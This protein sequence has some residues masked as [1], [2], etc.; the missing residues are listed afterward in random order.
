MATM[1]TILIVSGSPSF[2][3]RNNH[4]LARSEFS[5]LTAQA[6]DEALRLLEERDPALVIADYQ[7]AD[8]SGEE[9][10]ARVRADGEDSRPAIILVCR[11]LPEDLEAL[12]ACGANA[13]IT[14]PVRPLQLIKTVGQF[15]TVQLVR[16]RRISLRVKVISRTDDLEFFCISHNISVTGMLIETEHHL[17]EGRRIVCTF[18]LPD[19]LAVETEGEIVRSARTLD[20]AHQYG[21]QFLGMSRHFRRAIDD[22]IATVARTT[23]SA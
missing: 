11:E 7:L 22:Y 21:I 12:A 4:L 17:D 2:L 15:L 10:C 16:S 13:V 18:S 6:S 20:G 1:K 5:I 23:P 19:S 3:E 8:I 14:R 9:F